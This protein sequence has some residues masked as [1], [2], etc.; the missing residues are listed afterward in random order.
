MEAANIV[1]TMMA[2]KDLA[3]IGADMRIVVAMAGAAALA[4]VAGATVV[5]G[6]STAAAISVAAVSWAAV[7]WAVVA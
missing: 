6:R 4:G 3:I 2:G 5:V 1:G 7:A